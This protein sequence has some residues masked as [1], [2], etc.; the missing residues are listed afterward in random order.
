MNNATNNTV[1]NVWGNSLAVRLSKPLAKTAGITEATPI[2]ILAEPGRIVI[3]VQTKRPTLAAMLETF[4]PTRHGGEA[5]AYQP[6][7]KEVL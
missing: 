7:G 6:R 2:R 3:E 5:M 1:V 4:D